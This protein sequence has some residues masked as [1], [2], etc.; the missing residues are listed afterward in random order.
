VVLC[1]LNPCVC[2]HLRL[3]TIKG[4]DF[5]FLTSCQCNDELG[6]SQLDYHALKGVSDPSSHN[7]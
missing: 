3:S 6:I 4:R 5:I 7:L 1:G 2:E